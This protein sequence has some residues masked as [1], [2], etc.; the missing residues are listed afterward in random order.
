MQR[1][2]GYLLKEKG[3][4]AEGKITSEKMD[5]F[6]DKYNQSLLNGLVKQGHRKTLIS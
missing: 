5:T 3:L 4:D 2:A 6:Y 1:P